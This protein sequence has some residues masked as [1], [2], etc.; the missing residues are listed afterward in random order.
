MISDADF[1]AKIMP[2]L[3]RQEGGLVDNPADP[4]GVTNLGIS[5][6]FL[7]AEG[8]LDLNGDGRMDGDIDG[9]GDVDADDI[10]ALGRDDQLMLMKTRFWDRYLY[11]VLPTI[12]IAR[13]TFSTAVNAGPKPAALILQRTLRACGTP[14]IED[15]VL[16]HKT[17]MAIEA[18]C[19]RSENAL[20]I[21]STAQKCE[22]A[23]WYRGLV[24]RR[25]DLAQFEAGWLNRA[26][27]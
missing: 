17:L 12:N 8:K 26:Y 14:V 5:L 24:I 16:G 1:A 27:E 25:P 18:F 22:T 2:T 23:G 21:F 13:H 10:R 15:G 19:G 3:R 9:D 20:L 6:R 4:G 11:S 7:R